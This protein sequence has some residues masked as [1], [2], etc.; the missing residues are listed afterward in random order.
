[1]SKVTFLIGDKE[2]TMDIKDKR[3]D[4]VESI[5]KVVKSMM[6]EEKQ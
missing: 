1:M 4:S 6:T 2:V 3:L 5:E